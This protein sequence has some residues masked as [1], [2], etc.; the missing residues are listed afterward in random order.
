MRVFI[1]LVMVI[2]R[3][4]FPQVPEENMFKAFFFFYD[5]EETRIL[6]LCKKA[7]NGE[8]NAYHFNTEFNKSR[9]NSFLSVPGHRSLRNNCL[10]S[11]VPYLTTLDIW[12]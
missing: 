3:C 9:G 5:L 11:A 2:E 8:K 4:F 10:S 12:V 6:V 7:K 1:E